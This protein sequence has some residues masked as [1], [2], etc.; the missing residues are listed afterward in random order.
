MSDKCEL[1]TNF[2]AQR[3]ES[4]LLDKILEIYF[5]ANKSNKNLN[6]I[7][8]KLIKNY[9][10]N[11]YEKVFNL[12]NNDNNKEDEIDTKK[13]NEIISHILE[14]YEIPK[15]FQ[16]NKIF[17]QKSRYCKNIRLKI[18]SKID[19]LEEYE[20]RNEQERRNKLFKSL[21]N[22]ELNIFNTFYKGFQDILIDI[23]IIQYIHLISLKKFIKINIKKFQSYVLK[24]LKL[25]NACSTVLPRVLNVFFILFGLSDS[26]VIPCGKNTFKYL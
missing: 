16:V 19:A 15:Y 21:L 7:L 2:N 17:I 4:E 1:L 20:A 18:K 13:L 23:K 14:T 11:H 10:K 26:D 9:L 5:H 24:Y 12:L 25:L 3:L 8:N 6:V 22:D